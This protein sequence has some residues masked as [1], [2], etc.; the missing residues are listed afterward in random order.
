MSKPKPV[1]RTPLVDLIEQALTTGLTHPGTGDGP[2]AL[3]L[4]MFSNSTMPDEMARH[5]AEDAG[6]PHANAAKLVAEA[7]VDLLENAGKNGAATVRKA[8]TAARRGRP[9]HNLSLIHI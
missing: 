1:D 7:L 9:G 5:F 6:L 8:E 3:P 4:P 2:I